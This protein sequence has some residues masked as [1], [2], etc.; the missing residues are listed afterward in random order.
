NKPGGIFVKRADIMPEADRILLNSV[1]RVLHV[2]SRGTLDAQLD[3][4]VPVPPLP[5][6]LVRTE[7]KEPALSGAK[8]LRTE[9]MTER[10]DHAQSS[11]PSLH[12]GQALLPQSSFSFSSNGREYVI[13]LE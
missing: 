8:G 4:E 5:P 6:P 7:V 3:R 11:V 10:P 1:A 13:T 2:G 12:S 9:A